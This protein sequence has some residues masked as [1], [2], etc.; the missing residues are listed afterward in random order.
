MIFVLNCVKTHI[1]HSC[2]HGRR[3]LRDPPARCEECLHATS[4][5]C[6]GVPGMQR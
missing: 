6:G 5:T 3:G 2:L 4:G 1:D